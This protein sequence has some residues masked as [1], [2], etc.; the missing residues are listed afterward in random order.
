MIKIFY[1]LLLFMIGSPL[2]AIEYSC[3][4]EEVYLDGQ[5][6]NGFLLIKKNNLRYEY[7]NK[8]LYGLVLINDDL[9][10][11]D[12]KNL[13]NVK[14]TNQ[15]KDLLKKVIDLLNEYPNIQDA[16]K[17]NQFEISIEKS[18]QLNFIYRLAISSKQLNMSIY[19]NDCKPT[20]VSDIFFQ[21][22]PVIKYYY[23]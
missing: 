12:N 14:Q 7:F 5:I 6:N 1:T 2:M 9:F 21:T 20:E 3:K 19:F 13:S 16:Y 4:F 18:N 11:Y 8:N 15:N 22:R 10:Y 23:Q 17:I